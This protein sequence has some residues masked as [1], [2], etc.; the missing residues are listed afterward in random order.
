MRRA[1]ARAD[2][3]PAFVIGDPRGPLRALPKR[4]TGGREDAGQLDRLAWVCG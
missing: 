4:V 1:V 2:L 3:G